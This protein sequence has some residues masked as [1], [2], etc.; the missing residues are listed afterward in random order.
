MSPEQLTA[1]RSL[2]G[3]ADIWAL[4]VVLYELL[5]KQRP[6]RGETMPSLVALILKGKFE[7]LDTLRTDVPE[8]LVAA[9][10][11][12]L[13]LEPENRFASV[14]ELM[15]VLAA[16]APTESFSSVNGA[17]RASMTSLP[18]LAPSEDSSAPHGEAPH[19]E[20]GIASVVTPRRRT[21]RPARSRMLLVSGA[22]GF[23]GA[24]ALGG[25][26]VLHAPS[27]S[28]TAAAPVAASPLPAPAPTADPTAATAEPAA[29]VASVASPTPSA[30]STETGARTAP[31]PRRPI[32]PA[33]A[34]R[35]SRARSPVSASATASAAPAPTC[36]LVSYFDE[37]GD[38]HFKQECP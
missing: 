13:E 11:K 28:L 20:T 10:H 30:S 16:F 35:S 34:A 6:F 31:E 23:L 32:A 8:P 2:D 1:S 29:P 9:I 37:R 26:F 38:K 27:G 24:V 4:G 25:F 5:T 14:G 19:G 33:P 22:V 15:D 7:K 21:D 12:C 36:H 18:P 17:A 3:R